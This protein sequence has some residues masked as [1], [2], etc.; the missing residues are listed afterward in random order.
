[1]KSRAREGRAVNAE[2][3]MVGVDVAKWRHVAVFRTHRGFKS[4]AVG[5][6]NDRTGFE[7]VA[8]SAEVARKARACESVVFALEATGHYGHAL[9]HFLMDRGY[10]VVGVNPAHTKKAKELEDNSPEKSDPKDADV[11]ADL[12]L[13]GKGRLIT[14]PRGAFADLRRLGKLRERLVVERTRLRNRYFALVDLL[15][16][17]LPSL[18]R[19]AASRTMRRLFAECPT[20]AEIVSMGFE[21]LQTRLQRWSRGHINADRSARIYQAACQ[22]IGIQEGMAAARLEMRQ[23]LEVLTQVDVRM[24]EVEQAQSEA[25]VGVPYADLLLSIPGIGR[26]TVA[27]VL[28][29]TG[30]LQSFRNADAVIKFSGYNLYS[31]SS[32]TQRGNTR[33]TKRGRPLLRRQLFLAACRLSRFGAPLGTFHR[34][35][36]ERRPG[37][38]VLVGGC[39]KLIRL[40]VA[41]VRDNKRYEPG[42]VGVPMPG[43]AA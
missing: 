7:S 10:T 11:I 43:P 41:L 22:T 21:Q 25:L 37:P 36:S 35:V 2:V 26:V 30:D 31:M 23:D 29:E 8:R 15:F 6:T 34:R 24:R 32:G 1:M 40:M 3:L 27:T 33:I 18:V 19:D 14:I 9:R 38:V 28:G 4:D 17:E 39:R 13:Q 16:P 5:F 20:P 12:A 42:R